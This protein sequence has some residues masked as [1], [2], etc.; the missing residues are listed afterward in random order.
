MPVEHDKF[1]ECE[2][3]DVESL[4][5]PRQCNGLSW[6]IQRVVGGEVQVDLKVDGNVRDE[7]GLLSA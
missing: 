4:G 3:V 7:L 5:A 6:K 1:V 2:P